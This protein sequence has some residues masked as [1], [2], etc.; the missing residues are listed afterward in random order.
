MRVIIYIL[1]LL[2]IF[3]CTKLAAQQVYE[4]AT[5]EG[6][7]GVE[8]DINNWTSGNFTDDLLSPASASVTVKLRYNYYFHRRWGIHADF[9][10]GSTRPSKNKKGRLPSSLIGL[11]DND[12]YIQ[13]ATLNSARSSVFGLLS[14]GGQYRYE[15][16]KWT[17]IPRISIG[18][19]HVSAD[20]CSFI[21]KGKG[22]NELHKVTHY[23][24]GF[25]NDELGLVSRFFVNPSIQL[26]HGLFFVSVGY[27]QYFKKITYISE[28]KE[29]YLEGKYGDA[30][31][32]SPSRKLA[33]RLH[34]SIG[35]TT[36]ISWK[37]S[38]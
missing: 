26:G 1:M 37:I 18:I 33:N 22:N 6:E 9:K 12:Y 7:F 5:L 30:L 35:V 32:K 13:E 19:S 14:V 10:M 34:F 8:H 31:N 3:T 29:V 16:R 36:P 21:L 15:R 38:K 24:E 28:K 25:R 2:F 23:V 4:Q 20:N 17:L 11:Y 27:T